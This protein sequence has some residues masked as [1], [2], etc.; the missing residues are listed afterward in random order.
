[1]AAAL[2]VLGLVLGV[3]GTAV[4][5]S[6]SL[7]AA[8]QQRDAAR[9]QKDLAAAN[10][11][12]IARRGEEAA[13]IRRDESRRLAAQQRLAIGASGFRTDQFF[14]LLV[15]TATR[16]ELAAQRIQR[17]YTAEAGIELQRGAFESQLSRQRARALVIGGTT[18]FVTGL[19]SAATNYGMAV[20]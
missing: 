13:Q 10:A 20:K 5:Y 6:S 8:S 15:D 12:E 1:M 14:D 9:Q 11:A 4:S 17:G 2:P 3:A 16:E 18:Q 19:G 7:Q